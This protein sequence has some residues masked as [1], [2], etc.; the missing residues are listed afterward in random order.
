M[1]SEE[2]TID[3]SVRIDDMQDDEVVQIG[4]TDSRKDAYSTGRFRLRRFRSQRSSSDR[5]VTAGRSDFPVIV[6]YIRPLQ[7]QLETV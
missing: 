4:L 1:D 7:R 2:S 6:E 3:A 5:T